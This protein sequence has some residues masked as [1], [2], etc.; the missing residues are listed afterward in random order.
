MVVEN[1]GHPFLQPTKMMGVLRRLE[2]ARRRGGRIDAGMTG[3]I[4]YE[5]HMKSIMGCSNARMGEEL[6]RD[7]RWQRQR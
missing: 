5:L 4:C 6:G 2:A 7:E 1:Q 3:L